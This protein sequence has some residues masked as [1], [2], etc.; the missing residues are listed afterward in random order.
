MLDYF[1]LRYLFVPVSISSACDFFY[2]ESEVH[3]VLFKHLN[4]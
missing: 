2:L 1:S 3:Y 4:N